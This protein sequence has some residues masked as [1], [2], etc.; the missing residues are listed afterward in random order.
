MV[1]ARATV[2]AIATKLTAAASS[3]ISCNFIESF[4]GVFVSEDK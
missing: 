4:Q 1:L 2:V 3:L